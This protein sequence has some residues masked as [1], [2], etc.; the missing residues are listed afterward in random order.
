[1]RLFSL[2]A[3]LFA[4]MLGC[5]RPNSPSALRSSDQSGLLQTKTAATLHLQTEAG[6]AIT[7]A[8]V[9]I[10]SRRGVPFTDN[11]LTTDGGGNAVV[12]ADWNSNE[13]ITIEAAN[14]V[15]TTFLDQ[16]PGSHSYT[17]RQGGEPLKLEVN[18]ETT[19]FG[20]LPS[21]GIIDVGIVFAAMQRADFTSFQLGKLMSPETDRISL[22]GY[23]LD[24]PSNATIPLQK[25]RYI[26]PITFNKPKYRIFMPFEGKYKIIADHAR[27]PMKTVMEKMKAGK[28]FIDMFDDFEFVS[29]S[30]RDVTVAG[31]A[32]M[33]MNIPVNEVQFNMK[34]AVQ[35]PNYSA[36]YTM[37]ALALAQMDGRY[38]TTDV[39]TV[40][41]RGARQ[42]A[43]PSQ[44]DSLIVSVLRKAALGDNVVGAIAEE[45]TLNI[46]PGN[47]SQAVEF[48]PV[49]AAPQLRGSELILAPPSAES[50][51][52]MAG[53]Y[54]MLS[55]VQ[56]I[57]VAD[58]KIE[59]KTSYWEIY[60][61]KW[62][63]SIALPEWPDGKAFTGALRWEAA[64]LAV[65]DTSK[66]PQL[67]PERLNAVN[68]VTRSAVD[69]Q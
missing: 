60:G 49:V 69:L 26:I 18:G 30:A 63:S 68:Y 61:E 44:S 8:K 7:G 25:E 41:M 46:L 19:G 40:A 2:T 9:L 67:G 10:G 56:V 31:R 37:L 15:R 36:D 66:I 35:A 47:L 42:L 54:A 4:A 1:M 14:L 62:P 6:V 45:M 17:L 55:A 3:L 50:Q 12:P 16:A 59:R 21:D 64:F 20:N 32:P 57:P 34:I 53:T 48:L 33:T 27:F 58:R 39:K 38:Y 51:M 22:P 24:V 28:S 65:S 11:F 23:T 52:H 43:Y 29:A 5:S 13:P